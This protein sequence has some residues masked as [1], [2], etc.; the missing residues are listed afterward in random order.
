M[1]EP[2]PGVRGSLMP[3]LPRSLALSKSSKELNS[4]GLYSLGLVQRLTV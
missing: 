2:E 4:A 3:I 1:E